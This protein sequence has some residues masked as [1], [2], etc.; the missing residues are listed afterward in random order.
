MCTRSRHTHLYGKRGTHNDHAR[1]SA[2]TV[3]AAPTKQTWTPTPAPT[4]REDHMVCTTHVS[5]VHTASLSVLCRHEWFCI[6]TK[7]AHSLSVYLRKPQQRKTTHCS[8]VGGEGAHS[9]PWAY[10]ILYWIMK[11]NFTHVGL[12]SSSF[13]SCSVSPRSTSF[14]TIRPKASGYAHIFHQI[15]WP[16]RLPIA[17]PWWIALHPIKGTGTCWNISD[18]DDP[19]PHTLHGIY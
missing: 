10:L 11:D 12:A 4:P 1:I 5:H 6:D 14:S 13:S 9:S 15:G 16:T 2:W 18:Q 3:P 19:S 8:E 17:Q 7:T